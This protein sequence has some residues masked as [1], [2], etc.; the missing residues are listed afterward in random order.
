MQATWSV[1]HVHFCFAHDIVSERE[2]RADDA[3]RQQTKS[4]KDHADYNGG[5][6]CEPTTPRM[7]RDQ[8]T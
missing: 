2:L 8:P 1:H 4:L 7:S 5:G 3:S 6:R